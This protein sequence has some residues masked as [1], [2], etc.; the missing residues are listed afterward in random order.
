MSGQPWRLIAGA[1]VAV[2][3]AMQVAAAADIQT[4]EDESGD[5]AI[6]ACTRLIASGRY[7]GDHLATL[8][9]N[10]GV[11]YG[12][13]GDF[14]RAIADFD[15]AL[16]L[17]PK[18]GGAY[19]NRGLARSCKGDFDGAIADFDQAIEL[20]PKLTAAYYNRGLAW[21]AKG[22]LD[23]AVADYGQAITLDPKYANAYYN[24]AVALERKGDLQRALADFTT[25][26]TLDPADTDGKAAVARVTK[27]LAGR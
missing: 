17:D 5:A 21:R 15:Q 11:E 23:R 1:A 12:R 3:L 20:D 26:T 19:S 10:R 6:A 2:M 16:K 18:D 13:K 22:D 25:F 8:H 9:G 4:C 7:S 27:T 24:R 14:D